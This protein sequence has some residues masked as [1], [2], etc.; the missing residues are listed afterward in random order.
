M[1][2]NDYLLTRLRKANDNRIQV[3]SDFPYIIL[4]ADHPPVR[5]ALFT[6]AIPLLWKNG[7]R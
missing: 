2:D 4:A 3:A 1:L 5:S 6:C 7:A